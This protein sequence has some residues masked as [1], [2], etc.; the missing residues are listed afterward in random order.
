MR[1]TFLSS[2][3]AVAVV[4]LAVSTSQAGKFNKA[5][6]IGDKAPEWSDLAGTDD[7]KHGLA[8]YKDAEAVVLVFTCNHCPVAVACEDRFIELQKDYKDKNVQ[9]I[10][11]NVNNLEEDKLDQMKERASQKGFN[12][13]YLYDPSQKI[14]K[15]YG[16]MITPEVVLLDKNRNVAYLGLLDDS[17]FKGA[18]EKHYLR[19]AIDAVLAGKSPTVAETKVAG[20]GCG[21][22]YE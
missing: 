19:D 3:A 12:F 4:A 5:I 14:A 16:A 11:V 8:D 6:S 10:A 13:P 20:N 21:I 17:Q 18:P 15:N 1:K 22:K 7:K 9:V 2:L